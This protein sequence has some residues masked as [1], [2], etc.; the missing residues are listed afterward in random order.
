MVYRT[1]RLAIHR[2]YSADTEGIHPLRGRALSRHLRV[3]GQRSLSERAVEGDAV[4]EDK[5]FAFP[6]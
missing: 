6:E 4:V 5:T 1:E 3:V 2:R